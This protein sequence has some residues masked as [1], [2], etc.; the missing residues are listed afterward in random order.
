MVIPK[1]L[2]PIIDIGGLIVA[3][4]VDLVFGFICF[5]AL[6]PD[7]VTSIAFVS[8]GIMMVLFVVRSCSKGQFLP[9]LIFTSVVFFFDYSF[10]LEATRAQTEKIVSN[11]YQNTEVKRLDEAIRKNDEAL[12][13][14]R[15]KQEKAYARKTLDDIAEQIKDE[16]E[17]KRQNQEDRK[18]LIESLQKE[19]KQ[20]T[21]IASK[22]IFNAVPDAFAEKRYTELVVFFLIFFGLQLIFVISI[23]TKFFKKK[24]KEIEEIKETVKVVEVEKKKDL[25]AE[26]LRMIYYGVTVGKP[27]LPKPY[28]METYCKIAGVEWNEESKKIFSDIISIMQKNGFFDDQNKILKGIDEATLL[29]TEI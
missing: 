12:N 1:K 21:K 25:K 22:S 23:D 26:I 19:D 14:L 5:R 7:K 24:E 11:V 2:E 9:W 4:V 6:S 10:A 15:G 18:A 8:I 28:H 20:E 17:Q 3:M 16:N 27:Y 13:L 29:M